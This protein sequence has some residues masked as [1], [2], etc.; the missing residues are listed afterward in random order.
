MKLNEFISLYLSEF[1]KVL[2]GKI[3]GGT[4]LE[5][6]MRYA[7]FPGGK[8]FRPLLVMAS[9]YTVGGKVEKSFEIASAIEFIHN[10]T[11]IHD[12]LPGMDNDDF[13]RGKPTLHKKFGVGMAILAG[14]ALFNLAFS[15]IAKSSLPSPMIIK[16]L[17][18]ITNALGTEGVIK[19]QVEDINIGKDERNI[20][21]LKRVYFLK[22]ASLISVSIECGGIIG[23][24]RDSV[25]KKLIEYGENLGMAFQIMDDVKEAK[26]G[27]LPQYPDFP[28]ILG[29][30][31]AYNIAKEYSQ[32]AIN[33]LEIFKDKGNLLKE[34]VY[35]VVSE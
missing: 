16:I 11:L 18:V 3:E 35:E 22:T 33:S 10:F 2:D 31:E 15:T 23:G 4:E 27:E 25:M 19:G 32:K 12:D 8:R 24:V 7:V 6:A 17:K 30:D 5:E 28:S 20:E 29:I 34:L 14:D 21:K 13:R 1:E 26:G 9:T